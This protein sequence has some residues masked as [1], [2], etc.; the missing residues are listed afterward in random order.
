MAT[1]MTNRPWQRCRYIAI[2]RQQSLDFIPTPM[3][4]GRHEQLAEPENRL[5]CLALSLLWTDSPVHLQISAFRGQFRPIVC[6][7]VQPSAPMY[8]T[9]NVSPFAEFAGVEELHSLCPAKRASAVLRSLDV[10]PTPFRAISRTHRLRS[11]SM[12]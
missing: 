2:I 12:H 11:P 5:E 9:P 10:G 6:D 4:L 8:A 3:E 7:L 1:P